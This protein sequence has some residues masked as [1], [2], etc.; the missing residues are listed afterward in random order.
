M[1]EPN[2]EVQ[3][4][5]LADKFSW[6]MNSPPEF[7]DFKLFGKTILASILVVNPQFELVL[8]HPLDR[9]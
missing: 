5:A 4:T 2:M 3:V 6:Q 8:A 1:K 9:K 7:L